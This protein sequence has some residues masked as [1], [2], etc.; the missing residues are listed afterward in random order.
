MFQEDSQD[1]AEDEPP[2]E[3]EYHM[4][5]QVDI[6]PIPYHEDNEEEIPISEHEVEGSIIEEKQRD[7]LNFIN[8]FQVTSKSTTVTWR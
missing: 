4:Y 8:L 2:D 7:V 5:N 6:K 1:A 3:E